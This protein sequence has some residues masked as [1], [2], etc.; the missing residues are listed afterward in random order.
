MAQTRKSAYFPQTFR[1]QKL[2]QKNSA[3]VSVVPVP[4]QFSFTA[5]TGELSPRLKDAHS[6]AG[7]LTEGNED[8]P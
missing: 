5:L 8:E 6:N 1:F 7:Y 2:F 4:F 3:K